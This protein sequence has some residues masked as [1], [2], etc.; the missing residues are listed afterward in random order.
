M[1]STPMRSASHGRSR[2]TSAGAPVRPQAALRAS[3]QHVPALLAALPPVPTLPTA[4]QALH[5]VPA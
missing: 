2:R 5:P 1:R 4:L 3:L